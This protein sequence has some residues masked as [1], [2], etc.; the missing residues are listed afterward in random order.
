[1]STRTALRLG[2]AVTAFVM[3][4]V[5]VVVGASGAL[6]SRPRGEKGGSVAAPLA[7]APLPAS[8]ETLD[9]RVLAVLAV[10]TVAVV[11]AG[12][13]DSSAWRHAHQHRHA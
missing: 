7:V 4:A 6:A 8:Q 1:M 10:V 9:W 5:M 3:A 12:I 13:A 11:L 2:A